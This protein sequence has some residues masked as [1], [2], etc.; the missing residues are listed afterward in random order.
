MRRNFRVQRSGLLKQIRSR[1][2]LDLSFIVTDRYVT[3]K[4]VMGRDGGVVPRRSVAAL[5]KPSRET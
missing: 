4:H 5:G 3:G 2:L 1:P